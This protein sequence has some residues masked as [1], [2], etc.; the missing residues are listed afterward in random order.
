VTRLLTAQFPEHAVL[1]KNVHGRENDRLPWIFREAG[2]DLICSRQIYFFDGRTGVFRERSAVKRDE[3]EL[4][5]LKDYRVVE[6][7]DL[8]VEDVPRITDLYHQLYVQKHS[9]L[10][11]QYTEQFVKRAVRERW[12]EFTGLRG[13]SGRL[14]GIFGC[15]RQE[16]TLSTPFI[17]Y[18]TRLP[19]ELGLYRLLV[20][21]LLRRVSN[22]RLLLNY[23][24][25]AGDFKR[26]RGGESVVEWNAVYTRHL[27]PSRR[28]AFFGLKELANRVA[29]PFL[30]SHKV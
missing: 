19:Q 11:P 22:E 6:H 10:N 26:R 28:A 24:S 18:D 12:L 15:Y 7:G 21:L 25:G 20:A 3:K 2:Y 13:R 4:R 8:T 9:R 29:Q 16:G 5:G 17:G 1:V 30:T 27:D 23:S 14:D